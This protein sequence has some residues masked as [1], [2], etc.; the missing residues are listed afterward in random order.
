M[1]EE[2]T[3]ESLMEEMLDTVDETIDTRQGSVI[4]DAVAPMALEN[5]Q[6]YVD[7]DILL[8]ETFADTAS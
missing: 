1:F 7:M 2:K 3:Y 8:S 6:M 5:A 4:Y